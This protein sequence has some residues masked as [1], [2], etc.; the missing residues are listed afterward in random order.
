MVIQNPIYTGN[1]RVRVNT[2]AFDVEAVLLFV[3]QQPPVTTAQFCGVAFRKADIARYLLPHQMFELSKNNVER[4]H[5]ISVVPYGVSFDLMKGTEI[6]PNLTQNID[7]DASPL[8][9]DDE[10]ASE[11]EHYKHHARCMPINETCFSVKPGTDITAIGGSIFF[12]SP[13]AS[14]FAWPWLNDISNTVEDIIII[15]IPDILTAYDSDTIKT[16]ELKVNLGY[17]MPDCAMRNAIYSN[18]QVLRGNEYGTRES[19]ID[20]PILT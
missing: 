1:R 14:T 9:P 4:L 18:Y 7:N 16:L 17:V 12:T 19:I 2:V 6:D 13:T 3:E 20:Y 11:I 8:S 5:Y 10:V 15:P